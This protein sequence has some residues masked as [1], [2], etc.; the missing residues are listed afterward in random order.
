MPSQIA[1]EN[2][3]MLAWCMRRGLESCVWL[4]TDSFASN[5]R[6]QVIPASAPKARSVMT[7]AHAAAPIEHTPPGVPNTQ[8][9][10]RKRADIWVPRGN[11]AGSRAR[12][13]MTSP[14]G[15][16][17]ASDR[18]PSAQE[19]SLPLLSGSF[20]S[21]LAPGSTLQA[22]LQ[23]AP[24]L[25]QQLLGPVVH[26]SMGEWVRDACLWRAPGVRRCAGEIL[27][28]GFSRCHVGKPALR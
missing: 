3:G 16:A 26:A 7:H 10:W 17:H 28:A 14:W 11:T 19:P 13:R 6:C 4:T 23:S 18:Q 15:H 2:A 25:C 8:S 27:T 24:C 20:L 22:S 21:I 9:V 1:Q 12:S 5:N